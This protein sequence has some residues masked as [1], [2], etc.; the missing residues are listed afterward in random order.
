M[1]D[2]KCMRWILA[3]GLLSS[4]FGSAVAQA[5]N[6]GGVRGT[7]VTTTAT[8]RGPI[9]NA[10]LTL[11]SGAFVA[12]TATDA[13]GFFVFM[14]VPPGPAT[15]EVSAPGFSSVSVPVCVEAGVFRTLPIRL[16]AGGSLPQLIANA[17]YNKRL[18]Q[19]PDPGIT[20]DLYSIG[21]C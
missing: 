8:P 4:I 21:G 9:K 20:S 13:D 14:A 3:A 1:A 12:S 11:L 10:Q 17:N 7:V 5:Q 15:I 19:L 2:D 16:R 18:Q 6:V